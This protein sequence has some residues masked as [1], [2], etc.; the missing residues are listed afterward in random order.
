MLPR[1][2]PADSV[3]YDV[4]SVPEDFSAGNSSYYSYYAPE[5]NAVSLRF[6]ALQKSGDNEALDAYI[7]SRKYIAN[8]IMHVSDVLVHYI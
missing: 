4:E 3:Y 2:L 5:F 8:G 7:R 6:L 1:S